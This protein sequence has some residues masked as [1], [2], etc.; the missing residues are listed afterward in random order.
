MMR[1]PGPTVLLERAIAASATAYGITITFDATHMTA[2]E[3]ATFSGARH[4]LE[5]HATAA[6]AIDTWLAQLPEA[7][8]PL[9]GH[10]VA[11]LA[12]IATARDGAGHRFTIEAL[13]VVA[14]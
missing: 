10:L 11:D 8:L 1:G 5:A 7:D 4:V 3:S 6:K 2:W 12:I 13:T 14:S 9:H